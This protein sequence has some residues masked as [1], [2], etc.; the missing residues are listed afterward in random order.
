MGLL[1]NLGARRPE[2]VLRRTVE[3][4]AASFV[5]GKLGV[6]FLL[7]FHNLSIEVSTGQ[8]DHV[9]PVRIGV[10]PKFNVLE[11]LVNE[12]VTVSCVELPEIIEF[13]NINIQL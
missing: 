7:K 13:W 4:C 2:R 6:N 8:I 3:V 12:K 9:L 5:G 1:Y 11:H 10:R